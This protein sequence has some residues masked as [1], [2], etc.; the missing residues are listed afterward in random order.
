MSAPMTLHSHPGFGVVLKK[1]TVG[2]FLN[3]SFI[4]LAIGP[5]EEAIVAH[6]TD[7]GKFI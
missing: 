1:K 2:T 4:E 7:K 5:E 6:A 3:W